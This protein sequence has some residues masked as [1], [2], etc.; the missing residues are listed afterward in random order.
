MIKYVFF[1]IRPLGISLFLL[2]DISNSFRRLFYVPISRFSLSFKH[3]SVIIQ[4]KEGIS[5]LRKWI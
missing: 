4:V 3:E 2:K 1:I 5:I